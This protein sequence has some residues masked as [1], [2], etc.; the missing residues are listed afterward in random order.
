MPAHPDPTFHASAKLAMHAPPEKLAYTVMLSP[1]F[2]QPDALAIVDLDPG[3][4]EVLGQNRSHSDHAQPGRRVSPF[5]LERL[6]IGVVSA[7]RPR[8]P[9]AALPD[10]SRASDPSRIY[11]IDTKPR[12]GPRRRSL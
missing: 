10:S 5:W 8:L 12:S 9:G 11:V 7:C 3:F 2:S 4:L 6:L 1:D